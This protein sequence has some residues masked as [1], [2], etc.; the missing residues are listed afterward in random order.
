MFE[1][2]CEN[3][4]KLFRIILTNEERKA[5]SKGLIT[6]FSPTNDLV[7]PQDKDVCFHIYNEINSNIS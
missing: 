3:G 5:L 6:V 2:K 4:D 7:S 1:C